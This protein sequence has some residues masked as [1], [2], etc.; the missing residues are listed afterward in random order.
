MPMPNIIA[1]FTESMLE[2]KEHEQCIQFVQ[3]RVNNSLVCA[4]KRQFSLGRLV[5]FILR[6]SLIKRVCVSDYDVL[7]NPQLGEKSPIGGQINALS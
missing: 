7:I 2:S 3:G 5:Y 6:Y 1:Y 4:R